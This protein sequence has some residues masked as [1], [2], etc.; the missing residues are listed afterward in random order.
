[1][2]M[3]KSSVSGWKDV[4][5]FT[6]TETL[7]NRAYRISFFIMVLIAVVSMPLIQHLTK[8][9]VAGLD[10]ASPVAKVYIENKTALTDLDF[11]SMKQINTF[12]NTVFTML[13]EDYDTVSKRI[14][15]SERS[16]VIATIKEENGSF[17]LAFSK[18]S[19]GPVKD[20][21]IVILA[22]Q[23][24]DTFNYLR[25]T[26]EGIN[27][28]QDE[29]IRAQVDTKTVKL[30]A[31]GNPVVDENK[32]ISMNEYWFIYGILFFL[33]M[34]NIMAS[35]Q[36]ASSVVMEK[37]SRIV[38][39]L[40]ISVK[41]LA[42]MIGKILAMLCAV[43]L[44]IISMMVLVFLSNKVSAA[45]GSGSQP[46]V[47][48]QFIPGNIFKNLNIENILLCLIL[49]ALGMIFYA[50]LAGLAGATVSKMEELN[51]GMTL[52]TMTSLVGVYIGLGAAN[53]LMGS[54]SN[55]FVI[56]AFLFPLSSPFILPGA[57]LI[58]KAS[59]LI[60]AGA[61]L[62]QIVLNVLMFRFVA[63]IYETLILHN[64]NR[65]R[66]KDLFKLNKGGIKA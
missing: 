32:A 28:A 58:G 42:L 60:A 15:A 45:M 48:Q 18:A 52:L 22:E 7:K 50:V 62:I 35:A 12:K 24:T 61:I 17:V 54:G 3:K 27:Q 33:M 16:S 51:E 38:E 56:F 19:K 55:A 9:G 57:I 30:D 37:S 25:L 36:V 41:P 1:M 65:I 53:V 59:L 63:S 31:Q 21:G 20:V 43:L 46:G 5:V 26:K 14:E 34:V 49:I 40:L 8:G 39:Y 66:I 23:M 44:Q 11:S 29:L 13:T 47:M 4:F 2:S 10:S 6:L 64:G